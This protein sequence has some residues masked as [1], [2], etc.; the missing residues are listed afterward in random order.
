MT[1]HSASQCRYLS[2]STLESLPLVPPCAPRLTFTAPYAHIAVHYSN[3]SNSQD[4]VLDSSASHNVTM[5]LA[6]LVLHELYT[7]SDNV[8]IGDGTCLSIAN[9]GFFTLISLPTPLLFIDV[10]H[11]STMSKNLISVSAL[12]V[13]NLINVLFFYS[14]FQV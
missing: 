7:T 4:W 11:V 6:T 1:W 5:D 10:L 3:T 2:T 9:I 8:I 13:D 14:F 12:S